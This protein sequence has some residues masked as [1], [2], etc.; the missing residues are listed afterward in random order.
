MRLAD[1]R[2]LCL[3]CHERE[4]TALSGRDLTL[5]APFRQ[6][7]CLACHA[8]HAAAREGLLAKDAAALCASCHDPG[9]REMTVAHKGLVRAGTD[10]TTCHEAHASEARHLVL[11]VRHPPFAEGECGACHQ[12]GAL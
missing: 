6:G 9:R 11:P 1:S 12:G 7:S 2:T 3:S 10:C 4:R 5:H 8:P